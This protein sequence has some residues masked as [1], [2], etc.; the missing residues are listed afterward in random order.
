MQKVNKPIFIVGTGRCGSSIF[1]KLLSYHPQLAWTSGFCNYF[2]SM[3]IINRA[4]LHLDSSMII[5]P[6]MRKYIQPSETTLYWEYLAPGISFATKDLKA[7]DLHPKINRRVRT[8]IAQ[9]QTTSRKRQLHKFTGWPR[10]EYL[11]EIFPDAKFIHVY[12]D[13]RAVANSLFEVKWW[14]GWQGPQNWIWGPLPEKYQKEWEDSNRAFIVLAA[15]Q[16]KI[17]MDSFEQAIKSCPADRIIELKY[18][19]LVESPVANFEKVLEMCELKPSNQ[20]LKKV[21]SYRLRNAND[22]WKKNLTL[23][24]QEL[25]KK[26]LSDHLQ[27]YGYL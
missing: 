11:L 13:G 17:L 2:P 9:I 3:P 27:K 21:G 16:W 12:R 15:I 18:E 4:V 24:Q 23:D 10:I 8:K 6:L 7:I 19:D 1:H 26:S 5:Q 25:L 20:F 14:H 22:K